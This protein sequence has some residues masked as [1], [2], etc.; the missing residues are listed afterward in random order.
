[1]KKDGGTPPSTKKG[2]DETTPVQKQKKQTRRTTTQSPS[3]SPAGLRR[4]EG[5]GEAEDLSYMD[6]NGD[7]NVTRAEAAEYRKKVAAGEIEDKAPKAASPKA[8]AA[9]P[10]AKA[11][12]PKAASPK[13][14]AKTAPEEEP[15]KKVQYQGSMRVYARI[16]VSMRNCG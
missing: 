8:K 3:E 1:M 16:V 14:A 7:G 12:S 2:A 6:D 10:K 15:A 11:A 5:A 4:L 9:S 13:K